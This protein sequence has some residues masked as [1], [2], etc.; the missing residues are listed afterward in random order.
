MSYLLCHLFKTEM[1]F[2]ISHLKPICMF[3]LM[4][5][6]LH[7]GICSDSLWSLSLQFHIGVNLIECD[8]NSQARVI[9]D[10]LTNPLQN[11]FIDNNLL[12]RYY[13]FHI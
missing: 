8:I 2:F 3:A 7:S 11:N 5:C 9:N 6:S 13:V 1:F 10:L 4:F 12:V